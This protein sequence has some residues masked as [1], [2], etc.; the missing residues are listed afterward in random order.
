MKEL[1]RKQAGAGQECVE[2]AVMRTAL[3]AGVRCAAV[4]LPGP[5]EL[6]RPTPA[7]PSCHRQGE[8]QRHWALGCSTTA[9]GA[10]RT[11][12]QA[13]NL[14]CNRPHKHKRRAAPHL[15][16]S[17][18]VNSC[19]PNLSPR[20]EKGEGPPLAANPAQRQTL[21]A[22]RAR[23]TGWGRRHRTGAR[24]LHRMPVRPRARICRDRQCSIGLRG[25]RCLNV[26]S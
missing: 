11:V 5:Q 15:A 7:Q 4:R 6:R 16:T 3:T 20:S 13:I 22:S 14:R 18:I 19:L 8:K 12:R 25:A 1:D 21:G 2:R 17:E 24:Y 10:D 26:W 9:E 23:Q